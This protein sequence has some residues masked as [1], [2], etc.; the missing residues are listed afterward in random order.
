MFVTMHS[1]TMFTFTRTVIVH[2]L[3]DGGVLESSSGNPNVLTINHPMTGQAAAYRRQHCSA[4]RCS[5]SL[6]MRVN[7][8]CRAVQHISCEETPEP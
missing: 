2:D 3:L 5:N 1:R 7:C 8:L 4:L 6:L